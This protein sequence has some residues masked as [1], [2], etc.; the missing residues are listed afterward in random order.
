MKRKKISVSLL[1]SLFSCWLCIVLSPGG[2]CCYRRRK[3]P[4][5]QT[6]SKGQQQKLASSLHNLLLFLSPIKDD[7]KTMQQKQ[8]QQWL[9]WPFPA[10][11]HRKTSSST[12]WKKQTKVWQ[13]IYLYCG[14]CCCCF[15]VVSAQRK[16]EERAFSLRKKTERVEHISFFVVGSE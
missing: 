5:T 3:W 11:N 6:S 1:S 12:G 9:K 15:Y 7:C 13:K 10:I 4:D 16:K 2:I 14:V 8:Q